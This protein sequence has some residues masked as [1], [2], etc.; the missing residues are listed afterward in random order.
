MARLRPVAV[1]R[2]PRLLSPALCYRLF[3]RELPAV[4][5]LLSACY[6]RPAAPRCDDVCDM[7][8]VRAH[9]PRF[10]WEYVNARP[11]TEG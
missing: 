1:L 10:S 4:V 9:F 8:G 2:L 11:R 6:H 7:A 5:A 3:S